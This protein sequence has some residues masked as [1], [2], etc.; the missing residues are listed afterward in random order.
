[1][2]FFK[3]NVSEKGE[4]VPKWRVSTQEMERGERKLE[5][6]HRRVVGEKVFF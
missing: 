1:M 2:T 4:E 3:A 5:K 6:T